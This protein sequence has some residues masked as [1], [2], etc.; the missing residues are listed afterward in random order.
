MLADL[1][2]VPSAGSRCQ[3][4]DALLKP[5]ESLRRDPPLRLSAG[6]KAEPEELPP[7]RP[8]Y[9]ALAPVDLELEFLRDERVILSITRCPARS[10]RT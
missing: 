3:F 2:D 10:L 1:L 4:P 9:G 8:V 6:R 7:P 5:P